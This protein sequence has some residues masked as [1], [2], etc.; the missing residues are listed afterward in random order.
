MFKTFS[1]KIHQM[2]SMHM[3]CIL[4]G[5]LYYIEMAY[6]ACNL[7]LHTIFCHI[8]SIK[9]PNNRLP[10]RYHIQYIRLSEKRN[11]LPKL[12]SNSF[13]GNS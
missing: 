7:F 10:H 5:E 6:I 1:C 12:D 9:G 8:N 2:V 3:V 4:I 13:H 11:S